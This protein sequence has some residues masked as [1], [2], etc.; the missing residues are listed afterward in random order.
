[1][2]TVNWKEIVL[3][4]F[5]KLILY[6]DD[7]LCYNSSQAN[8][9]EVS[10][11]KEY[12]E[13][14]IHSNDDEMHYLYLGG[15][16]YEGHNDIVYARKTNFSSLEDFIVKATARLDLEYEN[17]EWEP[18]NYTNTFCTQALVPLHGFEKSWRLTHLFIR[19]YCNFRRLSVAPVVIDNI[20][21]VMEIG[22]Q[23]WDD[24]AH[25][26]ETV[27]DYVFYIWGTSG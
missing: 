20:V 1:M 14:M 12:D 7:S 23:K 6:S 15:P 21:S 19:D 8:R 26:I 5:L 27:T 18:D 13:I 17:Y 22:P 10:T 2:L 24:T 3:H 9:K 11:M 4:S 25:V 16:D